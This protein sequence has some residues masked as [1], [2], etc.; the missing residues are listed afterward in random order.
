MAAAPVNG[1]S[2]VGANTPRRPSSSLPF[3]A[4]WAAAGIAAAFVALVAVG[5]L[6]APPS[7]SGHFLRP[8]QWYAQDGA[9][10]AA[11]G[12][13]VQAVRNVMKARTATYPLLHNLADRVLSIRIQAFPVPR[14]LTT[15]NLPLTAYVGKNRRVLAGCAVR[16]P[17]VEKPAIVGQRT[18]L[19]ITPP[20]GLG[21]DGQPRKLSAE[22]QQAWDEAQFAYATFEN[23]EGVFGAWGRRSNDS[24]VESFQIDFEP[25]QA[26]IFNLTVD[27]LSRLA[28][29]PIHHRRNTT[30]EVL[31]PPTQDG[32]QANHGKARIGRKQRANQ[33]PNRSHHPPS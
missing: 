8:S 28:T 19:V 7:S 13:E 27:L 9:K 2:I 24:G 6:I 17:G 25:P 20:K 16:G 26:G 23:D 10:Q 3:A 31:P 5:N 33:H 1:Y 29:W 30:V 14:I 21:A 22:G 12:Q 18:H 11:T 15:S 32:K 4:R